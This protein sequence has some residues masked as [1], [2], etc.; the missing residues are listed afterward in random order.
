MT[1]LQT[2][3]IRFQIF[4][5]LWGQL[6]VLQKTRG[7]QTA[8]FFS[9]FM[10]FFYFIMA[11]GLPV[12]ISLRRW[13]DVK[14]RAFDYANHRTYVDLKVNFYLFDLGKVSFFAW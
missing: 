8:F 2:I 3:G 5:T 14:L 13:R 6:D 1:E 4:K 12:I 11:C 10:V 7:D 9:G